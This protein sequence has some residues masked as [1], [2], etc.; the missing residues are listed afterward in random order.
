ME[1]EYRVLY[2]DEDPRENN[3]FER[4]FVN[5]FD[6]ST[7]DFEGITLETLSSQLEERNFDYLIVD[8]H[9]NEKSGCGFN[10]DEV[11]QGFLTKF[12]DFPA[13]LLTNY[14]EV[15]IEQVKDFDAEKIRSKKEYLTDEFKQVFTMRVKAKIDEYRNKNSEAQ[16]R[17]EELLAKKATPGQELTAEEE[18]E[19]I[20][21][22][23][24]LDES[25]AGD[26][27][28]IPEE[29]KSMTNTNRLETL[30]NKTDELIEKLKKYETVQ[31]N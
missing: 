23:S 4:N 21:L 13:M 19:L 11:L 18:N 2:I 16:I 29:M 31:E 6:V 12:P 17:I 5:D 30:L 1:N 7:V 15:A 22:D 8:F 25:I 3:R 20:Q 14:G 26:A 9:L 27:R 24:F 28:K 10:G